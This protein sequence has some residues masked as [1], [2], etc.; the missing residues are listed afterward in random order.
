LLLL[1][2]PLRGLVYLVCEISCLKVL[3]AE[4]FS[5]I[6]QESTQAPSIWESWLNILNNLL[7][8]HTSLGWNDAA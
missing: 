4:K 3:R 6:D 8:G 5:E 2:R 7:A 1:E